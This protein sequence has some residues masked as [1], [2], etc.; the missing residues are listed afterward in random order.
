VINQPAELIEAVQIEL[1]GN[2][3]GPVKIQRAKRK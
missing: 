2:K 3:V 1:A